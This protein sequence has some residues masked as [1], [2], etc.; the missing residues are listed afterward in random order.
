MV[1]SFVLSV[2]RSITTTFGVGISEVLF[3]SLF[4]ILVSFFSI[5]T[6]VLTF[7]LGIFAIVTETS[8]FF[9]TTG[10]GFFTLFKANS[11]L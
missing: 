8:S 5:I 3:L 7:W 11:S 10:S 2:L 4:E 9:A 6:G 1:V